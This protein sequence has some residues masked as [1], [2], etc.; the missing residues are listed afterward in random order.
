MFNLVMPEVETERLIL[1]PVE[2]NDAA[3]MFE[4]AGDPETVK[5]LSF[6]LHQSVQESRQ[7]IHSLFLKRPEKGLPEP[8]AL[9]L[10]ENRKMIGTCDI[11]NIDRFGSGEIGY[12]INRKYWNHG[13]VTEACQKLIELA[14]QHIGMRRIEIIHAV[15]NLRS[16]RVIEKCGF[17]LEGVRRQYLPNKSGGYSDCRQYSMLK[18]EYEARKEDEKRLSNEI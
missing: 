2:E 18:Q 4:Y 10:K 17:V 5:W 1:R 12:V 15:E 3:D 16:Q 14:F 11:H 6:P 7:I 13:Y 9:V 8:Y